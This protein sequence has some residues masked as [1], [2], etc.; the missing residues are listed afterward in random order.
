M[1][2]LMPE[3]AALRRK[4]AEF[5]QQKEYDRAIDLYI[6]S[7]Q[8]SEA[9]GADVDVGV[10]TKLGDLLLRAHRVAEAITYY[11][12]AVEYYATAGLLSNAIALGQ[13]I[14]RSAPGRSNVYLTMGR[15]CA[16]KGLRGE[17]T[18]HLLEYATRMQEEDR[19]EDAMRALA[20]LSAVAPEL[21]DV[22]QL[23]E[24]LAQRTGMPLPMPS[25]SES[26]ADTPLYRMD[27]HA[28]SEVGELPPLLVDDRL[29][30]VGL[31]RLADASDE[32]D[33][34]PSPETDEL[35]PLRPVRLTPSLPLATVA[36]VAADLAEARAKELRDV[37]PADS[38]DWILR[39][40]L[41][42]A[43]LQAGERDA[44]LE[45][46]GLIMQGLLHDQQPDAAEAVADDLIEIA[47]DQIAFHQH[48]VELAVRR[49]DPDR[50][51]RCYLDLAD[52]LLRTGDV[53]RSH[54]AYER[55]LE[56]DPADRRALTAL[57]DVA[58][59]DAVSGDTAAARG[60]WSA[61]R[62]DLPFA[63]RL[64][65]AEPRHRRDERADLEAMLIHFREG[66]VRYLPDD[67]YSGHFDLGMA[68]RDLGLTDDAIAEFQK[69]ARGPGQRL[70]AYEALGG[71]FVERGQ[72]AMALAALRRALTDPDITSPGGDRRALYPRDFL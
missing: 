43:L 70:P 2:S 47:P 61:D 28:F 8:L 34:L 36:T 16:R 17:A 40:R 72:F 29:V 37:V 65:V 63:L 25:L 21:T 62:R 58:T 33:T 5:E 15:L 4:A 14:L 69:A 13:K 38:T 39:R 35:S 6:R 53:L 56:I 18:R 54:A 49:Q 50:L 11:E 31:Q 52:A 23:V 59:R 44:G 48:R 7:V 32:T 9:S 20:D 30:A 42:D 45:E 60:T 41:A 64:R 10:L 66:V 46:L 68:F 19:V 55:V 1:V 12:R 51:R 57:G 27:P 22:R 3:A 71:C 26:S 67:D 24:D